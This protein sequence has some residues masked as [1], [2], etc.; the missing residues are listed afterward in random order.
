MSLKSSEMG[1]HGFAG[2]GTVIR[3]NGENFIIIGRDF[4]AIKQFWKQWKPTFTP[5]KS[6]CTRAVVI[7]QKFL[8]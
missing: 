8:R 5:V 2:T 4:A 1:I 6:K 7:H 3:H